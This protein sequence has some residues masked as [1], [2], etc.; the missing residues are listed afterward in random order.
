M[1]AVMRAVAT[2]T[3]HVAHRPRTIRAADAA[4]MGQEIQ[5]HERDC[6]SATQSR[7]GCESPPKIGLPNGTLHGPALTTPPGTTI[8]TRN[9]RCRDRK[10][11]QH[12]RRLRQRP[13]SHLVQKHCAR[14]VQ[15]AIDA[16]I[17][18]V[19]RPTFTAAG[20]RRS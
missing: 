11:R 10:H 7:A 1:S 17:R 16:D 14:T 3:A 18:H 12:T 19:R 20:T 2:R 8:R 5:R 15:V 4:V 13:A 9:P 6:W